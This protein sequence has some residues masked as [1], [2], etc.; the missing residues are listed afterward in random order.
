MDLDIVYED[1]DLII[2]NKKAGMVVHPGHG[3]YNGTL[4]NGLLHHFVELPPQILA[5]DRVWFIGLTKTPAVFW[6]W[7]KPISQWPICPDN[8]KIKPPQESTLLWYGEMSKKIRE[9]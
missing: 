6:S 7:P 5:I 3:N 1:D 4:I 2:V 8:F 9:P